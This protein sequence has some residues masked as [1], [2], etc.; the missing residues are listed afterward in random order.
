MAGMNFVGVD[1]AWGNRNATGLCVVSDG[2]VIASCRKRSLEEIGAWLDP[3][4]GGDCVVAVDAPLIVANES[5]RRPCES[6]ISHCFGARHAG[7]HSTNLANPVFRSGGRAA[8]L[9][10]RL[11]LD[12][13]PLE[14]PGGS[15][16]WAIE[17]YP[18]AALVGLFDLPLTLKY[19]AK[20]RRGK[21]ERREAFK[22]CRCLLESLADADPPLDLRA[23]SHW[24]ALTREIDAAGTG[25]ALDRAE[26]E[27]DAYICVY[28]GMLFHSK[29]LTSSRIV[30]DTASG[31]IVTPVTEA[32][33]LC[34][35][36]SA[37]G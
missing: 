12:T 6:T 29:G 4:V 11:S 5:G 28:V 9:A 18:H 27:M 19:K 23:S 25:A 15:G 34:L 20:A 7:A 16:R 8:E 2:E 24:D 33:G 3:Y 14:V 32:L 31:Y 30:G 37:H 17:V 36:A 26:D 13:D 21:D 22:R 10:R 35:D 1:L